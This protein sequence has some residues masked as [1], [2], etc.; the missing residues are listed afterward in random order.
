[1]YFAIQPLA[2]E[3]ARPYVAS[4]FQSNAWTPA[5]R[6]SSVI[7][8]LSLYMNMFIVWILL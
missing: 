7:N 1:M 6:V 4:V 2:M 5:D 3:Q 8:L